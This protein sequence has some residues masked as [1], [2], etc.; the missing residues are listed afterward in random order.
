MEIVYLLLILLAV[1]L[2][3][4]LIYLSITAIIRRVSKDSKRA[5]IKRAITQKN[6]NCSACNGNCEKFI[7]GVLDK[8]K[9]IDECPHISI[10]EREELVELLEIEPEING[11]KVACVMC[12]GGARA[13]NQYG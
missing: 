9:R 6:P 3:G 12:K 1:S 4:L 8:T 7:E 2:V 13:V 10:K 5:L 11:N